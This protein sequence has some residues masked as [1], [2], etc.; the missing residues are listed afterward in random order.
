MYYAPKRINNL[1][2][3]LGMPLLEQVDRQSIPKENS[4]EIVRDPSPAGT[5]HMYRAVHRTKLHYVFTETAAPRITSGLE[6]W[7]LKRRVTTEDAPILI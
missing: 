3:I 1:F 6:F 4:T 5:S 2:N 7:R